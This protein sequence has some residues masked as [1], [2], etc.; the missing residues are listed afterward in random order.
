MMNQEHDTNSKKELLDV[1]DEK[2]NFT[3]KSELREEVHAKGLW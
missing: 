1:F 2:G 3:G